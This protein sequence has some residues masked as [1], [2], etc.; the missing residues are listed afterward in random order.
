MTTTKIII[1]LFCLVTDYIL[2]KINLTHLGLTLLLLIVVFI[3]LEVVNP[4]CEEE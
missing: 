2:F 4:N 3:A 1:V